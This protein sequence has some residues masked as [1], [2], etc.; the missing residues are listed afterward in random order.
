MI[1]L[2]ESPQGIADAL[3]YLHNHLQQL[4]ERQNNARTTINTALIVLTAQLQ[5][6]TQLVGISSPTLVANT[7]WAPF[8]PP[9]PHSVTTI[10]QSRIWS[11]LSLPPDFSR[12]WSFG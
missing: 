4:L 5:Q 7:L 12:D 3:G 8:S 11:K 6:L 1:T 2:L 10:S 9:I